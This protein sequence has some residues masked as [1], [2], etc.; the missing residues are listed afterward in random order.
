MKYLPILILVASI[1]SCATTHHAENKKNASFN[2]KP[3]AQ[4]P[5][6]LININLNMPLFNEYN[7]RYNG[8]S[9]SNQGSLGL[10]CGAEIYLNKKYYLSGIVAYLPPVHYGEPVGGDI[11]TSSIGNRHTLG[12]SAISL[13]RKVGRW[14]FGVG[15]AYQKYEWQNTKFATYGY[16]KTI[17]SS[18]TKGLALRLGLQY[19]LGLYSNISVCWQPSLDFHGKNS[20]QYFSYFNV[21]FIFKM[22]VITR[23]R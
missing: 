23:K 14:D 8:K 4:E 3:I 18:V 15:L 2:P 16:Y 11:D 12:Y 10:S 22:P 21:E 13:M 17:D 19:Y 5:L 6:P 7:I 1:S 20:S 9:S